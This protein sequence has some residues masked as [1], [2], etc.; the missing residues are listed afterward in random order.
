MD[1]K[2]ETRETAE[3]KG[4]VSVSWWRKFFAGAE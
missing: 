3:K 1:E 2:A 4:N